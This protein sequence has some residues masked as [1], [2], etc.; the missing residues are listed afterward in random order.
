[1]AREEATNTRTHILNEAIR[2]L[3]H[4]GID[5]GDP[6]RTYDFCAELWSS[7]TRVKLSSTD[8]MNM[9]ALLKMART[10]FGDPTHMDHYVDEVGYVALAAEMAL[11]RSPG[12]MNRGQVASP[13][14]QSKGSGEDS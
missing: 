8:V 2:V 12:F 6:G 14:S 11:K 9:M 3:G 13:D 7:Y 5:H 1:M 10:K 4:R